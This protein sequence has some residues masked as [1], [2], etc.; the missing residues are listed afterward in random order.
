M[1]DNVKIQQITPYS[2]NTFKSDT[3][4][5]YSRQDY[6]NDI[7]DGCIAL[8]ILTCG[9]IFPIKQ[10]TSNLETFGRI[11]LALGLAVTTLRFCDKFL[12]RDAD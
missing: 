10:K 8:G 5:K 2:K 11:L 12:S 1:E 4:H 7:G 9:D 6:M 3:K